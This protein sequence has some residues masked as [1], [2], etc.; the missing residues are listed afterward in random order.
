MIVRDWELGRGNCVSNSIYIA[1]HHF[2]R[3]H[4]TPYLPPKFY[5]NIVPISPGNLIKLSQRKSKTM[6][7]QNLGGKQDALWSQTVKTMNG[8]IK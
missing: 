2:Q 3:G 7:M 4:N 8:I 6:V 5:Q 1:I